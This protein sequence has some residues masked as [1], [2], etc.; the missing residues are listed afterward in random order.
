[1]QP[2]TSK[3]HCQWHLHR[4]WGWLSAILWCLC[5]WS[6]DLWSLLHLWILQGPEDH[7]CW[8]PNVYWW[9]TQLPNIS[10]IW[11]NTVWGMWTRVWNKLWSNKM[12]AMFT[13]TGAQWQCMWIMHVTTSVT[14]LRPHM[15]IVQRQLQQH[16]RLVCAENTSSLCCGWCWPNTILINQQTEIQRTMIQLTWVWPQPTSVLPVWWWLLLLAWQ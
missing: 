10:G 4:L 11:P 15:H 5:V 8:W 6:I 12:R 16:W 13:A 1:M 2:W 14:G 7:I 3:E 9:N